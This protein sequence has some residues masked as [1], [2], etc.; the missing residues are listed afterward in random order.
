MP[1]AYVSDINRGYPQTH[2]SRENQRRA[3][4]NNS[5]GHERNI[6]NLT[7]SVSILA[8]LAGL[9]RLLKLQVII[10]S[11]PTVRGTGSLKHSKNIEP[12][13]ELKAIRVVLV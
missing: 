2:F 12:L 13:K 10:H 3:L 4:A 1:F 11:L 6:S 8:C 9:S 7:L 5:P